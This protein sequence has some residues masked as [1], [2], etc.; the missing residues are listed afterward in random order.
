MRKSI[1]SKLFFLAFALLTAQHVSAQFE[2]GKE[3]VSIGKITGS[4][5]VVNATDTRTYTAASGEINKKIKN[6]ISFKINEDD[7]T[8]YL[9]SSFTAVV[10]F[11]IET[12]SNPTAVSKSLTINFNKT[13]GAKY[14]P[15]NYIVLP[16]EEA[17]VKIKVTGL[18]ITG[19]SG[20]S[21]IP[22]LQ[23]ENTIK[24]LRY[25]N[26]A[27]SSGLLTPTFSAPV[28]MTDA[29]HVSWSWDVSGGTHNNMNQLEWAWVENEMETYYFE[30]GSM[31]LDKLFSSNAT[32]VDLDF[33]QNSYDIPLLYSGTGKLYYRVRAALRKNDGNV[34]TG[35]WRIPATPLDS[36][37]S[38]T[39]GH[40]PN[41]NWQSTTNFAENGKF[42]TVIQYFDGSLRSRQTVTKDN[43]KDTATG[44]VIVA[45]TIYDLQGRPNLQILPTPTSDKVIKFFPDFNRFVGMQADEDPAKYFDLTPADLKCQ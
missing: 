27:T 41:L 33:L 4:S 20:W 29:L 26:L 44:N 30:N 11:T 12:T 2:E 31:N 16:T 14:D 22:V 7:T 43:S 40:E 1:L 23:L 19:A 28:N 18:T 39:N 37:F 15:R 10:N 32:R 17:M 38:F 3:D 21:P 42:K 13:D 34:I 5:I 36:F 45:E 25:F 8:T 6:I 9:Q 35:P 24:V